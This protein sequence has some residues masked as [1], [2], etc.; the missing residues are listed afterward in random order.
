MKS[1]IN[2]AASHE[3]L[4]YFR[5]FPI[6]STD[7]AIPATLSGVLAKRSHTLRMD[8]LDGSAQYGEFGL[9]DEKINLTFKGS[10]GQ[11]LLRLPSLAW[12]YDLG[13]A[14]DSLRNPCQVACRHHASEATFVAEKQVIIGNCALYGATGG[15]V[16]I[17][18]IAG[19]RFAV[20][21]SGAKAIVEGAGLHLCEYMTS[22]MVIVLGEVSHNVGA[23][24]GG[25]LY[26]PPLKLTKSTRNIARGGLSKNQSGETVRAFI[27]SYVDKTQSIS[28]QGYLTNE[29]H[30]EH[31]VC[32]LSLRDAV[33]QKAP[34]E[35]AA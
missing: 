2:Y 29:T 4:G 3:R 9:E 32:C 27:T 15:T 19:D 20:R 17:H 33:A 34:I 16:M 11:A 14:N 8:V 30:L 18:G 6:R 1:Q 22:G 28:G 10:A 13:E 21:N 26:L 23:G 25:R 24:T 31:L 12:Q 35:G 5:T 7:R